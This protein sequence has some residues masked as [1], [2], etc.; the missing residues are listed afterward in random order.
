MMPASHNNSRGARQFPAVGTV[1]ARPGELI[2]PLETQSAARS[3]RLAAASI[4]RSS[5]AARMLR[6]KRSSSSRSR[7]LSLESVLAEFNTS[8]DAAPVSLAPRLTCMML[9]AA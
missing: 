8:L 1:N 6:M 3:V 5:Y 7:K 2:R 4:R 9:A